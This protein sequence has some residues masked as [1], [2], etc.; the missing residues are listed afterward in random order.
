MLEFSVILGK[1]S[2][3]AFESGKFHEKEIVQQLINALIL[4]LTK[5]F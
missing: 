4:D 5:C 3:N 2:H 1:K